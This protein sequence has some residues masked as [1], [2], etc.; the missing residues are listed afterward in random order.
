MLML[1]WRCKY[2]GKVADEIFPKWFVAGRPGGRACLT[3]CCFTLAFLVEL[4]T[5]GEYGGTPGKPT[6]SK[7][8]VVV[9]LTFL[10]HSRGPPIL[11]AT[12][13]FSGTAPCAD[14]ETCDSRHGSITERLH[15]IGVTYPSPTARPL[16]RLPECALRPGLFVCSR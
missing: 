9:H 7:V 3:F 15:S 4:P 2:L 5:N 12:T 8:S 6:M 16:S 1:L 14:C 13:S 10:P 11:S